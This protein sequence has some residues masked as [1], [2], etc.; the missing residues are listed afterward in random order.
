M[1][2]TILGVTI[3]LAV[4][5]ALGFVIPWWPSET[6]SAAQL[7]G[8]GLILDIVS[9]LLFTWSEVDRIRRNPGRFPLALPVGGVLYLLAYFASPT[10]AF[11]FV[12]LGNSVVERFILLIALLGASAAA[13]FGVAHLFSRFPPPSAGG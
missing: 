10:P 2:K 6:Q 8:V 4:I 7:I 3:S 1:T 13:H 11:M 5:F 12:F 9:L